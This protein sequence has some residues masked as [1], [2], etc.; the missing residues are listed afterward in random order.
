MFALLRLHAELG[1]KIK[2]N[3]IQVKRLVTEMKHVEMVIRLL[4]PG[5]NVASIA[6]KRRNR[7]NP[8]FI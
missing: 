3:R 6:A 5:Y 8:W 7:V 1:G 4:K 2:D